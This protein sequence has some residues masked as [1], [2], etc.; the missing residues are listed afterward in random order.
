MATSRCSRHSS[1]SNVSSAPGEQKTSASDNQRR[2]EE[3]PRRRRASAKHSQ[4]LARIAERIA[5]I[6]RKLVD[7]APSHEVIDDFFEGVTCERAFP[8][9]LHDGNDWLREAI[10]CCCEEILGESAGET[11]VCLMAVPEHGLIHG[12]VVIDGYMGVA[13]YFEDIHIG[14]MGLYPNFAPPGALFVRL[15]CF[16]GSASLPYGPN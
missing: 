7:E 15:I 2:H 16:D 12:S 10:A 11:A 9:L 14:V 1:S 13:L 4:S 3:N 5:R 6:K 8:L